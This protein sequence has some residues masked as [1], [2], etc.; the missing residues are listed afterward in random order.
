MYL[1]WSEWYKE[2]KEMTE[3]FN[4]L[5]LDVGPENKKRLVQMM[6]GFTAI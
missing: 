4:K 6:N 2:K 3:Q 1:N 5:S